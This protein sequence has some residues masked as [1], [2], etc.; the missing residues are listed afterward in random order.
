MSLA[1]LCSVSTEAWCSA[2]GGLRSQQSQ[3]ECI[4]TE[5][6]SLPRSLLAARSPHTARLFPALSKSLLL[7]QTLLPAP[8]SRAPLQLVFLPHQ[9]DLTLSHRALST[10]SPSSA[11][12]C[13]HGWSPKLQLTNVFP[14]SVTL[15]RQ[16]LPHTLMPCLFCSNVS[17]PWQI[18]LSLI[19]LTGFVHVLSLRNPEHWGG[20]LGPESQ[21]RL[22]WV[23]IN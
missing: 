14:P 11:P 20:E 21:T 15:S 1:K 6:T 17:N 12:V 18:C 10:Y 16:P 8:H 19:L 9:D 7:G 5:H 13:N 3:T 22:V 4:S 23:D 2:A